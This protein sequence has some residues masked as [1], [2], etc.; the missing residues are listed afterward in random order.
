MARLT[1]RS[2]WIGLMAVST[3]FIS[4]CSSGPS[5]ADELL[6]TA[7]TEVS[8]IGQIGELSVTDSDS[9]GGTC[10][11]ASMHVK[12]IH[13]SKGPY[14]SESAANLVGLIKVLRSREE[15]SRFGLYY[16]AVTVTKVTDKFGN[17]N[18]DKEANKVDV[19]FTSWDLKQI[20]LANTTYLN[21][22]VLEMASYDIKAMLGLD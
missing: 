15:F 1:E 21:Q 6:N 14:L 5:A 8:F 12:V 16:N 19:C 22:H 9:N 11:S 17:E 10:D 20:N 4:A 7:R 18:V 13:S 3:L 2:L